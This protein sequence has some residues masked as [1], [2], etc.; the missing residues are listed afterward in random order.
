M[1]AGI[2]GMAKWLGCRNGRA[3]VEC[4]ALLHRH[5]WESFQNPDTQA[6]AKLSTKTFMLSIELSLTFIK[7]E[8]ATVV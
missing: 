5:R 2:L 1:A 7:L 4:A 8:S 6:K 3:R